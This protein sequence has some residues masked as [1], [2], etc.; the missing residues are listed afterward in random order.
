MASISINLAHLFESKA[1]NFNGFDW[2]RFVLRRH[3]WPRSTGFHEPL[4]PRNR[5]RHDA[6]GVAWEEE[7]MGD[8]NESHL[9]LS[10]GFCQGIFRGP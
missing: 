7:P 2:L 3:R 8:L 10:G 1:L 4:P 5:D 9:T 6:G